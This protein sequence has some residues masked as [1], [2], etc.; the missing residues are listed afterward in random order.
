MHLL[1]QLTNDGVPEQLDTPDIAWSALTPLLVL[2]VGGL[3]L[4]TFTSLIP[5]FRKS[6]TALTAY[7]VAVSIG[8]VATSVPLWLRVQDVERGAFSTAAGAW[9]VDGFSVFVGVL[10]AAAAGISAL[11]LHDYLQRENLVGPEPFVLLLLSASGGLVMA[12]ANDLIVTFI[13]LEILSIAVYVLA[14][15]HVRRQASQEA[16]IKYFV[17]G[18]FASAFFLYGIALIYGATGSTSLFDISSYLNDNVLLSDGTLLA[19][20]GLLLVG[21]AFKVAAVPFHS[22]TPDVYQGSPSPVV[23]YMASGV[24]VAGFAGMLRVLLLA[25]TESNAADWQPIIEVLAIAS[26]V[27][28]AFMAI[29]QDDVKRT[30]AY[31]S[32]SHAG[33]IMIGVRAASDVGT[34]AALFYLGAYTFIVAGSF[35]VITLVGRRGDGSHKL[36]DY[37][38]LAKARPGLALAFTI[39]L[40]AQAGVP[41][42]SGF[43]AK[44]YVIRSAIE[45]E[46]YPL[47]IVAMLTAVVG[48]Y[49]YLRIIVAMYMAGDGETE[50]EAEVAKVAVPPAAG[51]GLLITLAVTVVVGFLPGL[52]SNF[53]TDALPALIAAAP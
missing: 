17:L 3:L 42:T 53:A 24:K 21:F 4:L 40:L 10:M 29:V 43:F 33:F 22:W 39:F 28:G 49:L 36:T 15:S 30:L 47:A 5:A 45:G 9:G 31:S 52:L 50:A 7:T 16:A 23:A 38:G 19:G 12:A 2:S 20:I 35:G 46:R 48:A 8:A 26:M 11:L 34:A 27:L 41:L 1:G 32:I 14:G 25:F 13:G 18:A 6:S 37:H 44:F 51:L